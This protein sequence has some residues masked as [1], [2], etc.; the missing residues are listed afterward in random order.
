MRK[1]VIIGINDY[2]KNPL[3][4]CINDAKAVGELLKENED[5]SHNFD[6][7]IYTKIKSK[8]KLTQ[9]VIDLFKSETEVSLLY[10]A[11]HGGKNDLGTFLVTPDAEKFS[12]GLSMTHL[13][14]IVS[15]SPSRNKIIILDCCHSGALGN[16]DLLN[17]TFS[18]IKKGVTIL[19]ASKS[20]EAAKETVN[21]HGVFT[22][23]LLLALS[24]GSADLAG[25]V[26]PGG[27]YS[28]I[29]KALGA[30]DQRPV[31]KTNINEFSV[32]RKTHPQV[33]TKILK[34]ISQYFPNQDYNYP[35][36]PSF[37]DTNVKG[38]E[39][40]N[41]PP[42]ANSANV[43][44]FKELQMFQSVGLVVPVNSDFMYFAAMDSKACK[45]TALGKHYW[46]LAKEN[47]I[48]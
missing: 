4:S 21:G 9:I 23:L 42:Y 18:V 38:G 35:L 14:Q 28:Y 12:L 32:L 34:K 10:F 16:L 19:T 29:D 40:K 24:G 8:D 15:D 20:N 1:A 45:L 22:N 25:N 3:T 37:E 41:K 27:V 30:H 11:G 48:K 7:K 39:H 13:S 26:T 47:R 43:A 33:P 31:F 17:D 6:I 5:E 36:D 44:K 2:L 46:W